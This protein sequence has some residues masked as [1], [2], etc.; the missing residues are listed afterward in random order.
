MK[1]S[2]ISALAALLVIGAGSAF[3]QSVKVS[4]SEVKPTA[5]FVRKSP[6][7]SGDGYGCGSNPPTYNLTPETS[8]GIVFSTSA[9]RNEDGSVSTEGVRFVLPTVAEMLA[10]GYAPSGPSG[11]SVAD[12]ANRE[13]QCQISFVM[14][15]PGPENYL[16]VAMDGEHGIDKFTGFAQGAYDFADGE[17]VFPYLTPGVITYGWNGTSW[18][19]SSTSS[20]ALSE[21]HNQGQMAAHGQGRLF[22]VTQD[23]SWWTVSSAVGKLAWC[24]VNGMGLI[25]AANGGSQLWRVSPGCTFHEVGVGST[26]G[27]LGLRTVRSGFISAIGAGTTYTAHTSP[28]GDACDAG[29]RVRVTINSS[30]ALVDGTV[31]EIHGVP[32]TNGTNI[33]GKW[34]VEKVT[35]T[36]VD[37][38]QRLVDYDDARSTFAG[39]PSSYVAGD[40]IREGF[41][42]IPS[43][44]YTIIAAATIS[45]RSTNPTNGAEIVTTGA[46]RDTLLGAIYRSGGEI[47][48]NASN[49]HIASM[50]MPMPRDCRNSRST[51]YNVTSSSY[52]EVTN[53][54][55]GR[56]SFVHLNRTSTTAEGFGD[57]GAGVRYEADFTVSQTTAGAGCEIAIAF[58]GTTTEPD[59]RT[60]TAATDGDSRSFIFGGTKYG[61]PD[62]KTDMRI[63]ARTIGG[64]LCAFEAGART[65]VELD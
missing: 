19:L 24:P 61:L 30:P 59:T 21:Q 23:P 47:L 48:D 6:C 12:F 60:F 37:L 4:P 56:C 18:L 34:I 53:S 57:T 65:F 36:T 26:D 39:C 51:S 7:G 22:K 28:G 13:G 20:A 41:A 29:T 44:N 27:L 2:A 46:N 58:G 16:R 49:R 54:S 3:A 50:F 62:G 33:E 35:D 8:C 43:F 63:F 31:M 15:A 1:R 5:G 52:V 45:S 64:G 38:H 17:L 42:N 55:E 9:A 10:S 40:T 32:A 11:A 14:G 25:A